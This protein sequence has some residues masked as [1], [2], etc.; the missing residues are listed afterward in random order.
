MARLEFTCQEDK[1][2]ATQ[3]M[4]MCSLRIYFC[5]F[6]I[7]CLVVCRKSLRHLKTKRL[8]DSR[9]LTAAWLLAKAEVAAPG[10][11]GLADGP[12]LG[13]KL[14]HGLVGMAV[15]VLTG[16]R[17]FFLKDVFSLSNGWLIW[18][19]HPERFDMCFNHP[20]PRSRLNLHGV[21]AFGLASRFGMICASGI[22]SACYWGAVAWARAKLLAFFGGNSKWELP[23]NAMP[24]LAPMSWHQPQE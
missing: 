14:G 2:V 24:S 7:I 22:C 5:S 19:G 1:P 3:L 21:V 12:S 6:V 8:Q 4:Q 10:V 15:A 18:G 20:F 11:F 9:N 17:A 13:Y 16:E 23:E